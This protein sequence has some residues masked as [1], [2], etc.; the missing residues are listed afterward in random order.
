[1]CLHTCRVGDTIKFGQSSRLFIL[2]G[3]EDLKPAEGLTQSAKK[4][5]A[6][7]E[8]AQRMKDKDREVGVWLWHPAPWARLGACGVEG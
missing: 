8:Y 1:M 7:L 4:Q 6:A 3:P 2:C 5:L